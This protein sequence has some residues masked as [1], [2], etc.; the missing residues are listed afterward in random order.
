MTVEYVGVCMSQ[1]GVFSWVKRFKGWRTG[2]ANDA[3]SLL[4]STATFAQ[5]KGSDQSALLVQPT[6]QH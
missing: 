3:G 4:S 2:A 6:N 1:T 5:V